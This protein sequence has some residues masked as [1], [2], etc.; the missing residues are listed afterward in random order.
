MRIATFV[1]SAAPTITATGV[2]RSLA[3]RPIA[4][5]EPGNT[6]ANSKEPSD[7]TSVVSASATA[8]P[9]IVTESG[10]VAA[11]TEVTRPLT[12]THGGGEDTPKVTVSRSESSAATFIGSV[13]TFL[14]PNVTDLRM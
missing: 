2:E 5:Y 4:V 10:G 8:V 6:F 13:R 1:T 12:F 3:A 14:V 7:F 9:F 11:L